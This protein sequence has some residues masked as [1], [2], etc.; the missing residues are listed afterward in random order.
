MI[1]HLDLSTGASGDKLFGALLELCEEQGLLSFNELASKA[2]EILPH[3]VLKREQVVRGGIAATHLTVHEDASQH[4]DDSPHSHAHSDAH[5]QAKHDHEPHLRSPNRLPHHHDAPHDEP[6]SCEPHHHHGTHRSWGSIRAL[7]EDAAACSV[8]SQATAELA[9][10]VFTRVALAEAKV[11]G[12]E[13]D[14]VHFHEVGAADSIIDIVFNSLLLDTLQPSAVYATPLALGHGTLICE[15]G[16][17]PVPAPAT[18]EILAGSSV[19]VYASGHKGELTT[20]TGAALI[21]EFVT[22]FA[23]LPC[24]RPLAAGYGAGSREIPDAPN[25]LRAISAEPAPLWGLEAQEDSL[26]FV[27]G[28]TQLE[29]NIDHLSA[30]ALAFACEELL[31]DGALDVW[32]EPIVMKK[33]RL[34]SKLMV[35]TKPERATELAERIIELTG[36]LGVRS[37]YLERTV[38]PRTVLTLE[39]PYGLVPFKAAEMGAPS[40]RKH[41]LRPE[42]DAVAHLCREHNL[43]YPDLYAELQEIAEVYLRQK[44]LR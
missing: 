4:N 8:I 3:V 11:H 18:G 13:P 33:G 14:K 1:L 31:A 32:Q 38:V 23:P 22:Q 30:E 5:C 25:I 16:E 9:L 27:E 29:C 17:L 20:P 19:P 10:S 24:S 6:C 37:A 26:L 15:H 43:K 21:A 12:V 28:L 44:Q 35:L 39:T 42:H 2:Q 34:A 36:S 41:W 7:I 40:Q